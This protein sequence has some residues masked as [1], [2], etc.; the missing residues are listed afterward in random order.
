M[1]SDTDIVLIPAEILA[2][3]AVKMPSLYEM[4]SLSGRNAMATSIG[5]SNVCSTFNVSEWQRMRL[6]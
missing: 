6:K 4:Y 1:S 5:N 3:R 2:E